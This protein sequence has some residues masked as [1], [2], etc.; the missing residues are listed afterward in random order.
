MRMR[1]VSAAIIV[2]AA[3]A[4]TGCG[5]GAAPSEPGSGPAAVSA[6]P[7]ATAED[8]P[9]EETAASAAMSPSETFLAWLEASRVPEPEQACAYLDDALI[10]RMIA[11]FEADWGQDPGGC[12]GLT[13]LSA[14]LY[15]SFGQSA[16][17]SIDVVSETAERAELFV[18]YLGSGDCGTVVMEPVAAGWIMTEQT[19]GCDAG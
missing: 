9:Q 3:V 4:L 5:A 1:A 11:E 8:A 6:A 13:E 15:A 18:T 10:E 2:A 19:E 14:Q 17:V 12:E 16:E 7:S